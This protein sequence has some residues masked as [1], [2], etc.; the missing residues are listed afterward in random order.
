MT[1]RDAK[2]SHSAPKLSKETKKTQIDFFKTSSLPSKRP[3][4]DLE[5]AP[6]I[7]INSPSKNDINNQT[8]E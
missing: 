8:Q 7:I 6:I 3:S 5:N 4:E 1:A 2:G